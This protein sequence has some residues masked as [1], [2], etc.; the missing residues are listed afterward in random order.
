MKQTVHI[1]HR[2][3]ALRVAVVYFLAAAAWIVGSDLL[4][5][6]WLPESASAV[7]GS[8]AKGMAFVL[9]TSVALYEVLRRVARMEIQPAPTVAIPMQDR[10]AGWRALA[11]FLALILALIGASAIMFVLDARQHREITRGQLALSADLKSYALGAW[12]KQRAESAQSYRHSRFLQD[13]LRPLLD[14]DRAARDRIEQRLEEIRKSLDADSILVLDA[15]G[16]ARVALGGQRGV[17]GELSRAATQA[18]QTREPLAHLLHR[19]GDSSG[20]TLVLDQI[21][22]IL[23]QPDAA[24]ASAVLVMRDDAAKSVLSIMRYRPAS[25]AS[26]ETV[27]VRRTAGRTE[28]LSEQMGK[29]VAPHMPGTANAGQQL[30]SEQLLNGAAFV[31]GAPDY[32]GVPVLATSRPVPG[33]DWRII[34]KVDVDE[35]LKPVWQDVWTHLALIVGLTLLAALGAHRLWRQQ[36]QLAGLR[37]RALAAERD[38]VG[39]H[40]DLLSRYANDMILLVDP[41]GNIAE[42]NERAIERY[43]YPRERLIGMPVAE[44]RIPEERTKV[45]ARRESVLRADGEVYEARHVTADGEIFPV[46]VS[47][48]PVEAGGATYIQ[49]INRDISDRKRTE[50]RIERLNRLREALSATNRAIV[51]KK[52]EQGLFE[53]ICEIVVRKAGFRFAWIAVTDPQLGILQPAANAGTPEEYLTTLRSSF[54][55]HAIEGFGIMRSAM[56]DGRL[57]ISQ[58]F[59]NDPRMAPW[60]ELARKWGIGSIAAVPILKDGEPF[61]LLNVYSDQPNTFDDDYVSLLEEMA[62]DVSYALGVMRRNRELIRAHERLELAM[63]GAGFGIW[64]WWDVSDPAR[65]WWSKRAGE[66]AGLGAADQA[67]DV[68]KFTKRIH[69]DDSARVEAAIRAALKNEAPFDLEY[70]VQGNSGTHYWLRSIG[71]RVLGASGNVVRLIGVIA[72][73]DVRKRAEQALLESEHRFR[74]VLDQSIAAVYVVQDGKIVYVNQRTREIFGYQAGEEFDPDPKSHIAPQERSRVADQMTRRLNEKPEAAY[75]VAATRRDGTPFTLGAH[76]KQASFD[77]RPAIIVVAQDITEKARAE[78]QIKVYVARLEQAMQSTIN[79]VAT[80][81]ELRDPYTHGHERR[82]GEVAAAIAAEMG[83]DAG[84]VEGIRIAGYLHDVGKIGVP[85]EI[86]SKPSRLTKAEFDLIK[87]H[88]RQSYEILKG[89]EFPW[90]VAEA[91]WQHHERIDGSGYPRSLKGEEVILEARILAVADTV[92][93]MSSHRPYR[94]GLGIDA[95]LAE[96]EK[97]RGR[98]YDSGAV[99]AC[100]RLFREK[101][102]RLPA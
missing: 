30:A 87:D 47:A 66:L 2:A 81:G 88:A 79:V 14:G 76:A 102:Y 83:L 10:K 59:A 48:R 37:E 70:R 93:A 32:R 12:L 68:R 26:A 80:I 91:A 24:T 92:E 50:A 99:D 53:K 98:L 84:R 46:E 57:V 18:T 85:A 63:Q 101:G 6:L 77:G 82:V 19:V 13:D 20:S 64:D 35:L 67:Y 89:V 52:S 74:A 96:I 54:E 31:E 44:L 25:G 34:A 86:L 21:V 27:I 7:A 100:L 5:L 60:H 45:R 95:A 55:N 73:I 43:G 51:R 61:A 29:S 9:V 94:P 62:N 75:S 40:L 39:K 17:S 22:P 78:E 71:H 15:N 97:C 49:S 56:R 33:T 41:Q 11:P 42:A 28:H 8:I 38:V 65:V 3:I 23:L 36:A 16:Q 72:D 1:G 90:P 58:D 69:P 4:L